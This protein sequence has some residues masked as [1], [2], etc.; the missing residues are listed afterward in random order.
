MEYCCCSSVTKSCSTLCNSMNCSAPGFP[1]LH[2]LPGF[3]EAHVHWVSDAIHHL[4]L[5]PTPHPTT[6]SSCPQSFS[7][8]GYFPINQFFA[9]GDQRIGASALA[10]VVPI[11]IQGWFPL[12]L[13]DFIPLL[14]KGL[15]RA[16]SSTTIWKH[17]FFSTEFSLWSTSH[18]HT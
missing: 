11:N 4:T 10:L 7:P 12:G 17:Q 8:S 6:F 3:A 14:S 2:Y 13:I 1:V 5:C 15:S 18:I 9:S 16:F